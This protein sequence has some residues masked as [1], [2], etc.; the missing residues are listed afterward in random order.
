MLLSALMDSF[1]CDKAVMEHVDAEVGFGC[2]LAKSFHPRL[3]PGKFFDY[4]EASKH[5]RALPGFL[6]PTAGTGDNDLYIPAARTEDGILR[7][8]L[9]GFEQAL[10]SA[11]LAR[12]W[13]FALLAEQVVPASYDG[14][15]IIEFYHPAGIVYGEIKRSTWNALK[16]AREWAMNSLRTESPSMECY[17]CRA[18]PDCKAYATL[19]EKPGSE[20]VDITDKKLLAQRLLNEYIDAKSREKGLSVRRKEISKRLRALAQDDRVNIND[21]FTLEVRGTLVEKYSYPQIKKFLTDKG[22][23]RDDFAKIDNAAL[24]SA[25]AFFPKAVQDVLERAKFT[26]TREPE[27]R[28]M[29][30]A[31]T[32][33]V[34]APT[35]RGLGRRM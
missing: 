2:W 12:D 22:L 27:V 3:N 17:R 15:V 6:A 34:S 16:V 35:M 7:V 28:G 5:V 30:Q 24:K 25:V 31:A 18:R 21:L 10:T 1:Y 8:Q 29:M 23:W 19:I 14:V 33:S 4:E 11:E 20:F 32:H 9:F 13:R 26:E